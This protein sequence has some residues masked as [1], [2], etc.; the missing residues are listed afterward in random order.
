MKSL[1]KGRW[2][3]A[4]RPVT[5]GT[6]LKPSPERV[7]IIQRKHQSPGRAVFGNA[8]HQRRSGNSVAIGPHLNESAHL[9]SREQKP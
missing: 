6:V 3:I 7:E 8:G 4:G 5:S 9:A 1:S 2:V